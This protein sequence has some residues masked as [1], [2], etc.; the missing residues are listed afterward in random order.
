[1]PNRTILIWA[2]IVALALAAAIAP[3]LLHAQPTPSHDTAIRKVVERAVNAKDARQFEQ[4]ITHYREALA[5]ARAAK[6]SSWEISLLDD[7]SEQYL[8]LGR[9]KETLDYQLQAHALEPKDHVGAGDISL[10]RAYQLNGDFTRA[11]PLFEHKYRLALR[12]GEP[13]VV[14]SGSIGYME[15][16]IADKNYARALQV[17]QG[18]QRFLIR[19]GYK[20]AASFKSDVALIKLHHAVGSRGASPLALALRNLKILDAADDAKR[21]ESTEYAEALYLVGE[22]HRINGDL[23]NARQFHQR[24]LALREKL[25]AAGH[26]LL[27]QSQTAVQASALT[28]AGG[29]V[30]PPPAA[31]L[32]AAQQT[33]LAQITQVTLH[34]PLKAAEKREAQMKVHED[35]GNIALKAQK[36]EDA[37]AHY[38]KGL[39]LHV[40]A[41]DVY[42][43]EAR[44]FHENIAEALYQLK[45]YREAAAELQR[46]AAIY[47][48]RLQAD[49]SAL[50]E[51]YYKMG[52]A[53]LAAGPRNEALAAYQQAAAIGEKRWPNMLQTAES[54][55]ALG[56]LHEELG[57][58]ASALPVYKR[59]LAIAAPQLP[60]DHA[61]VVAIRSRIAELEKSAG[62]ALK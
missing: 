17:A 31:R 37:I 18:F 43:F 50:S 54:L 39:A 35:D 23:G 53:H 56:A 12:H 21:R 22:S 49:H 2:C 41:R 29:K 4:A 61:A 5:M 25:H 15:F 3:A 48:T 14:S 42:P 55:R 13:G 60:V 9:Y 30:Q 51:I 62:A 40:A 32:T 24:A 52:R 27:V 57:Q 59:A 33:Q 11:R 58:A 7:I 1:M 34:P 20:A 38:R 8:A 44:Q 10:A 46:A 19:M 28:S 45:R 36:Y 16:L 26:P 6:D 47:V